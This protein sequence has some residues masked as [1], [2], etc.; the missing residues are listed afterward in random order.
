MTAAE[1]REAVV[2]A[3]RELTGVEPPIVVAKGDDGGPFT[4]TFTTVVWGGDP[5]V[6]VRE[7]RSAAMVQAVSTAANVEASKALGQ[8]GTAEDLFRLQL[9]Q[10]T[11]GS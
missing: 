11:E 1:F 8:Q 2:A 10:V 3:Y 7:F 5:A 4:V 9:Q 6:I